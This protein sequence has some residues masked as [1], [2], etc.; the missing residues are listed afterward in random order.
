MAMLTLVLAISL[1]G[2]PP[3]P[4]DKSI[5]VTGITGT[6]YNYGVVGLGNSSGTL[7][8]MSN[9]HAAIS[10]GSFTSEL[11]EVSNNKLTSNR[12]SDE[13]DFMVVLLIYP[14]TSSSTVWEGGI[15]SKKITDEV[16]TIPFS[17]FIK[18][19]KSSAALQL[20]QILG[21]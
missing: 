10:G 8:A 11:Y 20:Q 15:V 12:F 7:V 17:S 5:Q 16:T 14:T 18:T 2:C 6:N 9:S 1:T 19:S 13:G 21:E 4:P 3:V